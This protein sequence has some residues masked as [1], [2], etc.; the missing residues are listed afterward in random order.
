MKVNKILGGI[1]GK[2]KFIIIYKEGFK[3]KVKGYKN[4]G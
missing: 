3:V 2:G 4:K 1:K